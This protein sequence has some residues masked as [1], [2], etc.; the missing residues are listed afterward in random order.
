MEEHKRFAARTARYYT[1]GKPGQEVRD[2]WWAFHGYGQLAGSI[3]RK[4]EE[5]ESPSIFVLAPEGLSRFYWQGF[6]GQVGASWMTREDRQS[7]ID[8]YCRYFQDL[9]E[10]YLPQLPE[11]VRL[12][13]LGF[14]QG[15][16][17]MLRWVLRNRIPFS[18][19]V[20]W[21]G[22]P[23]DD[24]FQPGDDAHLRTGALHFV[25]GEND[26]YFNPERLQQVEEWARKHQTPIQQHFFDGVHEVDRKLL[27]QLLM[28]TVAP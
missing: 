16:P 26:P 20:L 14:S 23:P 12:H 10:E 2:W 6:D 1:I 15:V 7:E 28:H 11:N 24:P 21:A 22:L 3:I 5:L 13:L 25:C 19:L 9:W 18:S 4:F 8:D 17:T 27:K